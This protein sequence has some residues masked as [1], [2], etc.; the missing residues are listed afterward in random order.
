MTEKELRA[1]PKEELV[2]ML[3]RF[4]E[5]PYIKSYFAVKKQLDNLA[6][7]IERAHIDFSDDNKLFKSFLEFGEKYQKIADSLEN[8]QQK[9]D[10]EA[11]ADAKVK[12]LEAKEGTL[13]S[14]IKNK[15]S[16]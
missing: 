12:R 13:E 7:Q 9:I 11:L 6:E 1:K 10:K 4:Y 5:S 15:R 16:E 8:I 3:I 14:F 2:E